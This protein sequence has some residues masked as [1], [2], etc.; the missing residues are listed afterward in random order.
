MQLVI[1]D[2]DTNNLQQVESLTSCR[3]LDCV[4]LQRNMVNGLNKLLMDPRLRH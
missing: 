1:I 3:I 4:H 2:L